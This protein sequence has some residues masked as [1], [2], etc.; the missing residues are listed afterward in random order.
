M[1]LVEARRV[2]VDDTVRRRGG[3]E[4]IKKHSPDSHIQAVK[5]LA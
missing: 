1:T 5:H 3:H 2:N 4:E